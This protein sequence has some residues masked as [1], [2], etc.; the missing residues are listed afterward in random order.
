MLMQ[1]YLTDSREQGK[2]ADI[3]YKFPV[4]SRA[5]RYRVTFPN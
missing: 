2:K 4:F 3:K 1:C 5:R